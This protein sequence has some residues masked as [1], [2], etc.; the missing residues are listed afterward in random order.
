MRV[1]TNTKNL[2]KTII[3]IRPILAAMLVTLAMSCKDTSTA[4]EDTTANNPSE[5]ISTEDEMPVEVVQK[6]RKIEK[7][8]FT[9]E[10]KYGEYVKGEWVSTVVESFTEESLIKQVAITIDAEGN[11]PSN[12]YNYEPKLVNEHKIELYND[13]GELIEI[14]VHM[15]NTLYSYEVSNPEEPTLVRQYDDKGNHLYEVTNPDGEHLYVTKYDIIEKDDN[16]YAKKSNALWIKYKKPNHVNFNDLDFSN[17]EVLAKSY[18]V[19]E[20]N[21]EL[22]Q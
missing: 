16:G 8:E 19:I 4:T 15:E 22:Y 17:A 5:M 13:A 9:A 10:N 1:P 18:Q 14:E 2:T 21:Y 7:K 20:F 6:I 3:M 12:I 11:E